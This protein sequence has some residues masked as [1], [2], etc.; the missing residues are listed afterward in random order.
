MDKDGQRLVGIQGR[1]N[2]MS[3]PQYVNI[4]SPETKVIEEC[5][6]VIKAICK[7]QRFGW[8]GHNPNEDP[9]FSKKICTRCVPKWTML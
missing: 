4:G 5:S 9:I 8:F 3:D 2:G 6:E 1:E 7:A